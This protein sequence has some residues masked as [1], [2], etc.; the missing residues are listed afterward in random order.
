MIYPLPMILHLVISS[1]F[2]PKEM[3]V[4]LDSDLCRKMRLGASK[5]IPSL[6]SRLG[7]EERRSGKEAW[8]MELGEKVGLCVCRQ[9]EVRGVR[10]SETD[11]KQTQ[12][13]MMSFCETLFDTIVRHLD[14]VV[15][16]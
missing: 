5:W 3:S 6:N 14:D 1:A 7:R 4:I 8:T 9:E 11:D 12:K 15:M 13:M 10:G 2:L 16:W